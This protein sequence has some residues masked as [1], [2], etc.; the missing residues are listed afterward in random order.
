MIDPQLTSHPHCGPDDATLLYDFTADY[1]TDP[2]Q[3]PFRHHGTT[4]STTTGVTAGIV[5]S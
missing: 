5:V 1:L 2:G 3:A 4:A